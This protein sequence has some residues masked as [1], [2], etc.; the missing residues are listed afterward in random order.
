VYVT[1]R[2]KADSALIGA[3]HYA[4]AD[5]DRAV[6]DSMQV[7][8]LRGL[9]CVLLVAFHVIGYHSASGMAVADDSWWRAFANL[10]APLRMPLF[11]F[12][13]GFVYAY[14][15]VVTGTTA[16]FV[17]KKLV[18]LWLPLLTVTTIYYLA[19]LAVP[20][21]TGQMP[22]DEIWRTYLFSYVHLWFLQALIVVFAATV[23]LESIDGL[24]TA[25]RYTLALAASIA[26]S[27]V[28]DINDVSFMSWRQACY[29]AP[30]FLLG[31]GA[32]RYADAVRARPVLKA[33][34]V[35][36]VVSMAAHS[37]NVMAGGESTYASHL[38]R[39]VAG[40]AGALT[41]LSSLPVVNVMARLGAYSYA[42][43]LFHPFF[44]FPT[45]KALALL[46]LTSHA[47]VFL[48]CLTAG[49]IGPVVLEIIVRRIPVAR[50]A[51]LGQR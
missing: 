26:L 20:G 17:R 18:R 45:R 39:I 51:L 41:L 37:Y 24:A 27:S 48:L 8:V 9:A 35:V 32:N 33:C 36:F 4:A 23:L 5:F 28:M 29:L 40:L 19:T 50:T 34:A 21:A 12:L 14:R 30:F 46:G 43:Y 42:I 31:L 7:Q 22:L 2:A 3:V 1:R 13:S 6:A 25:R 10:V 11:T 38:V 49:L 16:L 44:V 15:P 47:S